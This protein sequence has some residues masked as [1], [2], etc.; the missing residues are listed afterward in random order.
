MPELVRRCS[1]ILSIVAIPVQ[2]KFERFSITCTPKLRILLFKQRY[3]S[4]FL[5]LYAFTALLLCWL[6][7]TCKEIECTKGTQTI[8]NFFSARDFVTAFVHTLHQ[9]N[10]TRWLTVHKQWRSLPQ[11]PLLSQYLRLQS[12][13]RLAHRTIIMCW[14]LRP[15]TCAQ[16]C[17]HMDTLTWIHQIF[18]Q[19][20]MTGTAYISTTVLTGVL[21][22]KNFPGHN[23]ILFGSI[24]TFFAGRTYSTPCVLLL[25][26]HSWLHA[27]RTLL[28][29]GQSAHTFGTQLGVI[30]R[31]FR[32]FSRIMGIGPSGTVKFFM[33]AM[34]VVSHWIKFV[35]IVCVDGRIEWLLVKLMAT[36]VILLWSRTKCMVHGRC[37][38]F[39]RMIHTIIVAEH[40]HLAHPM[41]KPPF[42]TVFSCTG[43]GSGFC[44]SNEFFEEMC[45]FNYCVVPG[46]IDEPWETFNDAKSA[47]T[48]VEWIK[49]ASD[50]E[51]PFFLAVGFHRPHIPYMWADADIAR[52]P[53][54]ILLLRRRTTGRLVT[55]HWL[56]LRCMICCVTKATPRNLS[57]MKQCSL[58][59]YFRHPTI[60]SPR[61]LY[62]MFQLNFLCWLPTI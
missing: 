58:M 28:E 22:F 20:P 27:D 23:L 15:T 30:T 12:E 49:N 4:Q 41:S 38:I 37:P 1:I 6:V 13:W 50:Y 26:L 17:H 32:S 10:I 56:L 34:L 21:E 29:F 48:A 2:F 57:T 60:S 8:P 42:P 19:L 55:L 7:S 52:L 51:E 40:S 62:V 33:K 31:H 45:N 11:V 53:A 25:E 3:A 43:N 47:L 24:G 16:K 14:W 59:S 18:S 54:L 35:A 39:I 61:T 44:V 9:Y 5:Q 46:A 36:M